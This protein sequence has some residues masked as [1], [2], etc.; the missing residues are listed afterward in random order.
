M[1][2]TK[3]TQ[4][5]YLMFS[6]RTRMSSSHLQQATALIQNSPSDVRRALGSPVSTLTAYSKRTRARNRRL[7]TSDAGDF[8]CAS[9]QPRCNVD[10]QRQVHC[11][12]SSVA[13]KTLRKIKSRSLSVNVLN[14]F[15]KIVPI[16]RPWILTITIMDTT[17]ITSTNIITEK[18]VKT[19]S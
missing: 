19:L 8:F 5:T 15:V 2:M 10:T 9:L 12:R 14:D 18:T 11:G 6:C 13:W 17:N 3:S 7:F 1:I 4:S 16:C